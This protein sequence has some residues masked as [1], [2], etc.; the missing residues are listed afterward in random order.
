M[1]LV[2]YSDSD[3]GSEEGANSPA[4]KPKAVLKRKRSSE[5][6]NDDL[7]P[8]PAAFHDLYSTNARVSTRDDPNLHGGRKRAVPHVEGVPSQTESDSLHSL[9]QTIK[10]SIKDKNKERAKPLPVPDIIPSLQSDLGAPLPLHVSL[11]RTLQ[12]KT[13]D[14]EQFLETLN[15]SLRRAAVQAFHFEF[16]SL[17]WVPNFERNRWFLVLSIKKPT[18]NELNKLLH[19]CNEAAQKSGHPA[20][21]SGGKGDGPMEMNSP[22]AGS[23]VKHDETDRSE[24]FHVSIAWNLTEPDPEWA[25]LVQSIDVGRC[26]RSPQASFDV[27]KARVGNVVHNFDL[28]TRRSSLGTERGSLGLG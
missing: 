4:Q 19:A 15:N 18:H 5:P 11:S 28:D 23:R 14:R 7:P 12:I 9:I 6:S 26:V 25:S 27:I 24:N 20:L 10:D 2:Q 3:S 17:K 21:Y 8:L 16:H 1:S 13:N 22:T